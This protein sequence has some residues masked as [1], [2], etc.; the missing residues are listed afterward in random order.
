MTH[1]RLAA[2]ATL[3]L[4]LAAPHAVNAYQQTAAAGGIGGTFFL[5]TCESDEV[6]VGIAGRSGTLVNAVRPVC[7]QVDNR[8]SWVASITRGTDVGNTAGEPFTLRCNNDEIVRA[9]SGTARGVVESL[10]VLC[11]PLELGRVSIAPP[12]LRQR[13]G[14][15][16]GTPFGPLDCHSEPAQGLTGASDEAVTWIALVCNLPAHQQPS[17]DVV[18]VAD[19]GVGT[20][21]TAGAPTAIRL[22]IRNPTAAVVRVPW[23]ITVGG[24]VVASRTDRV[25]PTADRPITFTATWNVRAGNHRVRAELDPANTLNE[26]GFHRINNVRTL[27]IKLPSIACATGMRAI[28]TPAGQRCAL[29]SDV[30]T[31]SAPGPAGLGPRKQ[32]ACNSN[33]DCTLGYLCATDPCGG[34]CLRDR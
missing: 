20:P 7:A 12:K 14:G 27:D 10:A 25:P 15:N 34:I 30:K 8:G 21:L 11:S 3:L 13:T 4:A 9:V 1:A 31:C 29:A 18:S 2:G 33:A 6:L 28:M 23:R 19:L 22:S 17:F 5:H 32:F 26:L 16:S 24:A